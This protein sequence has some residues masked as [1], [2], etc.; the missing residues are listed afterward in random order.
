VRRRGC[1]PIEQPAE[2]AQRASTDLVWRAL[3]TQSCPVAADI[4]QML[5]WGALQPPL[6]RAPRAV[7]SDDEELDFDRPCPLGAAALADA[8]TADVAGAG[9]TYRAG[10]TGRAADAGGWVMWQERVASAGLKHK[11]AALQVRGC[12]YG[13]PSLITAAESGST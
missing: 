9:C 13:F 1:R 4:L 5:L 8:G 2:R 3:L 10:D 7:G 6:G 12:M 11:L